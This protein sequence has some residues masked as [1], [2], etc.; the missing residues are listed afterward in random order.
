M[1]I[2]DSK[3]KLKKKK[4]I[5]NKQWNY[6]NYVKIEMQLQANCDKKYLT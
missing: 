4:E 2:S 3:F 5:K 1:F 6:Q